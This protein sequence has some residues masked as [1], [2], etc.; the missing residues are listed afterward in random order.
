MKLII[1]IIILASILRFWD[2]GNNPPGLTWDEASLGYNTYSILQT[3][4]DEYGNF[5]PLYL[6]SFGDYKPALYAYLDIPFVAF[7][8]L[9][10]LSVRLPAA[11]FGVLTVILIYFFALELLKNKTLAIF[12]AFFMAISPWSIQFSRAGFEAGVALFFNILG[13]Y[14]FIRAFNQNNLSK[15]N[16]LLV[17]SVFS[18]FLSTLT[19]QAS[20]LFAPL[21]L[22]SLF[23]LNRNRVKK[24]YRI[25]LLILGLFLMIVVGMALLGGTKRLETLNFFAYQR[26]SEEVAQISKEDGLDVGSLNFQILHGEWFA[27]TRGLFE[28]YLIYLSPRTYFIDGDYS[29]RHRVPDLGTLYYFSLLLI[30]L[31]CYFFLKMSGSPK[32]IL[33]MWLL[34]APLSAVLS[35]DLISMLRALNLILP[36]TLMEG[37]GLYLI[38]E[39]IKSR[40][41]LGKLILLS[42]SFFILANFLIYIDRYFIHAPKE[43]SKYWLYGY[44]QVTQKIEADKYRKVMM[45]DLW[46]QPYIYYLF[47]KKYP[48]EKF[49]MQAKLDQN[50]V[51]VGTVRKIDNIEFGHFYWPD[52][53]KDEN[54]LFVGTLEELPDKDVKPY[55]EY[56][57]LDDI[58]FKDGEFAFRMVKTK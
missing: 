20:R 12:S 39:K 48:P 4:K 6:K 33:L 55:K 46:G 37:A 35:R 50:S 38:L 41:Y 16:I 17:V 45:T 54:S 1:L 7:L 22:L 53:R 56:E 23:F 36:I 29:Q 21:L 49:Q 10:E 27:Y 32:K 5:L 42:L 19:Y 2:L 30:P 43:Y 3:G 52:H 34:L 57:I 8:G 44:K 26:S 51:D 24:D 28:R 58:Y 11:I 31:G 15:R 14:F 47:Y 40:K 25:S 9:S 18:L 13:A